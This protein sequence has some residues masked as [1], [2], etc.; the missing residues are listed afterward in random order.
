MLDA[1]VKQRTKKN[2]KKIDIGGVFFYLFSCQMFGG[3][4]DLQVLGEAA[5]LEI[6]KKK[7]NEVMRLRPWAWPNRLMLVVRKSSRIKK[8]HVTDIL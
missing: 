6:V 8:I 2:H 1:P 4:L 3:A 7:H 5:A